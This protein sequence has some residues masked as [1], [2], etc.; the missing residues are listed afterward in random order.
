MEK[1]NKEQFMIKLPHQYHNAENFWNVNEESIAIFNEMI[2]TA[3]LSQQSPFDPNDNTGLYLDQCGSNWKVFR[4][5]GESDE[6]FR[7]RIQLK[8][9]NTRSSGNILQV[10]DS[11]I[12]D[13]F[14]G[15]ERAVRLFEINN[16]ADFGE[17]DQYCAYYIIEVSQYA[18]EK[19]DF[20]VQILRDVKSAGVGVLVRSAGISILGDDDNIYEVFHRRA[21]LFD[22]STLPKWRDSHIIKP[23]TRQPDRI[24]IKHKTLNQ[25]YEI[26][27]SVDLRLYLTPVADTEVKN[28]QFRTLDSDIKVFTKN[29]VNISWEITY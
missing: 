22:P 2:E 6:D 14:N 7:Q 1:I 15:D 28:N 19:A 9:S 25:F 27:C 13:V 12:N 23:S 10:I 21:L 20:A 4:L 29:G 26:K 18:S 3:K 24:V 8:I 17:P 11:L 5:R 16:L